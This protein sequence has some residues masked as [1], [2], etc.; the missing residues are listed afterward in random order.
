M[1][2][3]QSGE[4]R[5]LGGGF[6]HARAAREQGLYALDGSLLPGSSVSCS[7]DGSAPET[8]MVNS[9]RGASPLVIFSAQRR[10][11]STAKLLV[12][13]GQL[14]RQRRRRSPSTASRSSRQARSRAAPRRRSASP[15]PWTK[16]SAAARRSVDLRGRKPRKVKRW[17]GRPEATSAAIAAEGPGMGRQHDRLERRAHQRRTGIGEQRGAGVRHQRHIPPPARPTSLRARGTAMLVIA[18]RGVAIPKW[19]R[20]LRVWRVSSAAISAPRAGYAARAG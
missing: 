6:A 16:R 2:A 8:T 9:P 20:S 3:W 13:L 17:V 19:F 18:N 4:T 5:D 1:A 14:A 12:D 10:E 11:P 15:A 7:T